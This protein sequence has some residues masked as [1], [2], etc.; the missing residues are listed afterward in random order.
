MS[1]GFFT[2]E[3]Q[4]ARSC[5][6]WFSFVRQYGLQRVAG[7]MRDAKYVWRAQAC[8]AAGRR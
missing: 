6:E 8:L 1:V 3:A 7:F 2:A 4:R 5:T